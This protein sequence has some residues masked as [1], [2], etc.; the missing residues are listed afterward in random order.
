[1][2]CWHSGYNGFSSL[3]PFLTPWFYWARICC[4]PALTRFYSV[5]RTASCPTGSVL[6]VQFCWFGHFFDF[7]SGLC[8][9]LKCFF[10]ILMW[11]VS[12]SLHRVLFLCLTSCLVWHGF[13]QQWTKRVFSRTEQRAWWTFSRMA[14]QLWQP[15]CSCT[16]WN[17]VLIVLSK[18]FPWN[19]AKC[20]RSN[21]KY[22]LMQ[23]YTY[24][25][26]LETL[27]IKG[28]DNQFVHNKLCKTI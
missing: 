6:P 22:N 14:D 7:W 9:L 1:M 3:C 18:T 28:Q 25:N 21:S 17:Q 27:V 16:R 5:L 20:H 11:Y 10:S 23:K 15:S 26:L 13:H 4:I 12:W 2:L 8:S 24:R 19:S